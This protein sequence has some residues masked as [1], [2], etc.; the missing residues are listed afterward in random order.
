MKKII[1]ILCTLLFSTI[2][3]TQENYQV[4]A[5]PVCTIT[6][7]TLRNPLK[8]STYDEYRLL[9]GKIYKAASKGSLVVEIPAHSE[10]RVNLKPMLYGNNSL[11]G[12]FKDSPC[13]KMFGEIWYQECVLKGTDNI[14]CS[15]NLSND[16]REME[17][18]LLKYEP[19][20]DWEYLEDLFRD[21]YFRKSSNKELRAL[22]GK[23]KK[24][25]T[26]AKINEIRQI[27][28][29]IDDDKKD[30]KNR[31]QE[32]IDSYEQ[33]VSQ[34]FNEKRYIDVLH[35][36]YGEYKKKY[37][38]LNDEERLLD[39]YKDP[40]FM[41]G[42]GLKELILS[43][44]PGYGEFNDFQL[45]NEWKKFLV[46]AERYGSKFGFLAFNLR[47]NRDRLDY[48][49]NTADYIIHISSDW[50]ELYENA[51][52][53]IK[54]GYEKAYKKDWSDLPDPG[55][56]PKKSVGGKSG[57]EGIL[58]YTQGEWIPLDRWQGYSNFYRDTSNKFNFVRYD[59]NDVS[60][61]NAFAVFT[62]GGYYSEE[63]ID[64]LM[65]NSLYELKVC[66]VDTN[67]NEV[68]P[69]KVI[70]YAENLHSSLWNF[71]DRFNCQLKFANVS[72]EIMDKIEAGEVVPKLQEV[73]L[74]YGKFN[75]AENKKRTGFL[76][77]LQKKSLPIENIEWSY[78]KFVE[79]NK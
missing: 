47:Y 24:Y 26:K 48:E 5:V 57:V 8:F 20:D 54:N 28:Q 59:A 36:V 53:V 38:L 17:W 71:V 21:D 46:E 18:K 13:N 6:G 66:F 12:F 9:L 77:S 63:G 69:S 51:I 56:W 79:S 14:K 30:L 42:E 33:I 4:S 37:D 22:D 55:D 25:F 10:F 29:K 27:M 40:I 78:G 67:G 23:S 7:G 19:Y 49:K 11:D 45:H 76:K 70:L 1:T 16:G 74:Y 3:F 35:V 68:I 62:A 64:F 34:L 73:N 32:L 39:K 61:Y 41:K 31:H 15:I 72:Q 65:H 43:G 52:R 50:S 2:A 44:K 75:L 58:T 60:V